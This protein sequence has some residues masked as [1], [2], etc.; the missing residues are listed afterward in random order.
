MY[1]GVSRKCCDMPSDWVAHPKCSWFSS[2]LF[3][4]S[5]SYSLFYFFHHQHG[6]VSCPLFLAGWLGFA[7]ALLIHLSSPGMRNR[8]AS[9]EAGRIR[10]DSSGT[11]TSEQIT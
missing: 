4:R 6:V 5:Q 7:A 10:T 11:R 9:I 2:S 3:W 8:V 1:L